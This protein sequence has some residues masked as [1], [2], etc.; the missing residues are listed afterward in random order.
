MNKEIITLKK[1]KQKELSRYFTGK[2]CG[3]GH[4]SERYT[5]SRGCISCLRERDKRADEKA[6]R[7][8]YS[9]GRVD[10]KKEYDKQY[11]QKNSEAL[12]I[13]GRK[14]YKENIEVIRE[15]GKRYRNGDRRGAILAYKKRY[16]LMNKINK[17][18]YDITIQHG[19]DKRVATSDG[20][21]T[22]TTLQELWDYQGQRCAYC[23]T[24]ISLKDGKGTQLDHIQPFNYG[25]KHMLS[26]VVWSCAQC[27]AIK[28]DNLWI[29][30]THYTKRLSN[31]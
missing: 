17:K 11:R 16:G 1:A 27:N 19:V 21:I 8:V 14:Y 15:A 24:E 28:K 10:L 5:V 30:S 25:G 29:P 7:K 20:S 31:V 3:H 6:K 4:L 9:D 26:N 12:R 18:L 22:A 2:P 23:M 13:A